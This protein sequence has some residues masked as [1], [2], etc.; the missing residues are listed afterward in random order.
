MSSKGNHC[1]LLLSKLL[2]H[3]LNID[4]H[5]LSSIFISS[6]NCHFCWHGLA[7][8][9]LLL[10][11]LLL[12]GASASSP[13]KLLHRFLLN[14]VW[15]C[16]GWR[17]IIFPHCMFLNQSEKSHDQKHVFPKGCAC[18]DDNLKSASPIHMKFCK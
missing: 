1:K 12:S 18:L 13:Q 11:L 9:S 6:S 8:S 5:I 17:T 14:V 2:K 16:L 3:T 4:I 7:S 15:S 10:W